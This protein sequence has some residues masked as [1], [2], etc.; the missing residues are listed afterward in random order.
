ME[1]IKELNNKSNITPEQQKEAD[2]KF[3]IGEYVIPDQ[4]FQDKVVD[5][6]LESPGTFVFEGG[7]Y[8]GKNKRGKAVQNATRKKYMESLKDPVKKRE[9]AKELSEGKWWDI[10]T[11]SWR[12]DT[13]TL[14]I[15]GQVENLVKDEWSKSQAEKSKSNASNTVK[16]AME[17]SSSN[18]QADKNKN[19]AKQGTENA[20]DLQ[21]QSQQQRDEVQEQLL[22][23]TVEPRAWYW[24]YVDDM[25]ADMDPSKQSGAAKALYTQYLLS[26][27]ANLFYRTGDAGSI[28]AG[29]QPLNKREVSNVEKFAEQKIKDYLAQVEKL[30]D[31]RTESRIDRDKKYQEFLQSEELKAL[32]SSFYD[33]D[34]DYQRNEANLKIDKLKYVGQRMGKDKLKNLEASLNNALLYSNDVKGTFDAVLGSLGV[35]AVDKVTT[36]FSKNR[37]NGMSV[38]TALSATMKALF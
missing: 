23:T 25:V 3:H 17:S 37:K 2:E 4:V 35:E 24:Q 20:N 13:A 18:S 1:D 15:K 10:N 34:K 27:L 12:E 31:R 22:K 9:V 14:W 11:K 32:Q 30:D 5:T 7:G 6:L 28:I 36:E 8:G 33:I 19:T 16:T 26:N 38:S 29:Q 21:K